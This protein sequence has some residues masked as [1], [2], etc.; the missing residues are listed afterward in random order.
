MFSSVG[1]RQTSTGSCAQRVGRGPK[2]RVGSLLV[3]ACLVAIAL[4]AVAGSVAAYAATPS[5]TGVSPDTGPPAG[6]TTVKVTGSGFALGTS[7]TRIT[8][9]G[10]EEEEGEDLEAVDAV[11]VNC[12]T[13][14]ECSATTPELPPEYSSVVDVRATVGGMESPR[15]LADQFEYQG[16]FLLF[17]GERLAIGQTVSLH[18]GAGGSELHECNGFVEATTVSDGQ[19][20]DVLEIEVG[21]FASC[22]PQEFLGDLPFSFSLHLGDDGSATFEGPIGVRPSFSGCVYEGDGM[23]GSFELIE[24]ALFVFLGKTLPL[25]AEEEPEAGCTATS[26]VFVQM[27]SAGLRAEVV[28]APVPRVTGLSPRGGPKAGGTSV[29][30]T[31]AGFSEASAVRFGSEE[32]AS[33]TVNSPTSITAVSPAGE[34]AVA[35]TVTGPRGTSA[36]GGTGDKFTYGPAVSGIEPDHGPTTGETTVTITGVNLGEASAVTFGTTPASAFTVVSPTSITAVSPAGTGTVDVTV[37][38]PEGTSPTGTQDRFSYDVPPPSI[39]GISPGG[40]PEAGGTAVTVSGANLSGATA[41]KFGAT[42]ATSFTVNSD[43]SLTAVSPGGTGTVDVSVTTP[44]GTSTAGAS[45]RFTY[46]PAESGLPEIGRCAKVTPVTEGKR[47]VYHGTYATAHCTTTSPTHEGKFEWSPGPG[48]GRSFT[49]TSKSAGFETP[50]EVDDLG[51][52]SRIACDSSNE[53][54]EFTGPRTAVATITFSA[55]VDVKSKAT[56]Q[57]AG[58]PAGDVQTGPLDGELGVIEGGEPPVIGIAFR[59]HGSTVLTNIECGTSDVTVEG[60]IIAPI[61]AI[62]AMSTKHTLTYKGRKGAQSTTAFAGEPPETLS[63]GEPMSLKMTTA[64]TGMESLEVKA[65]G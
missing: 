17:D 15:T 23:A 63:V 35:V 27:F 46:E 50:R 42:N 11:G 61:K 5:V 55:C 62:D 10:P 60:A 53:A 3:A 4:C 24:S 44:R 19:T 57:S 40:G 20:A 18:G 12:T 47:L 54:G 39:S 38:T 26:S 30:L 25:V 65:I 45:D 52:F 36:S 13:T 21:G 32:A 31:G 22:R 28:G 33:F 9:A 41:V 1:A 48:A 6:G 58:E 49:G 64:L 37:A 2:G 14:T 51:P 43:T 8:F 29:T 7:A 34:G 16:L 56:C 59:P